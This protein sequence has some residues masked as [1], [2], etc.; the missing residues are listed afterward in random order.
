MVVRSVRSMSVRWFG[1]TPSGLCLVVLPLVWYLKYW[2]RTLGAELS[3]L[4]GLA[5]VW[6]LPSYVATPVGYV[7]APKMRL[8]IEQRWDA[9]I[10]S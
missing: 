6:W 5:N 10:G 4:C 9:V 8:C 3:C 1:R 7:S 2:S